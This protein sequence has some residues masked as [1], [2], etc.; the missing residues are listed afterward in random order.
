M[1]ENA[2]H[3]PSSLNTTVRL[4]LTPQF[5]LFRPLLVLVPPLIAGTLCAPFLLSYNKYLSLIFCLILFINIV[6]LFLKRKTLLF[7]VLLFFATGLLLGGTEIKM[8]DTMIYSKPRGSPISCVGIV[9][10]F[11]VRSGDRRQL[12][13][14]V[15]RQRGSEGWRNVKGKMRISIGSLDQNLIPGQRVAVLVWPLKP[16]NFGNPG[17][18]DYEGFLASRGIYSVARIKN[19]LY[20][21]P[22]GGKNALCP[23]KFFMQWREGFARN[24]ENSLAEPYAALMQAFIVGV[25]GNL[26]QDTKDI[27][28]VCGTGHLLAISGLHMGVIAFGGYLVILFLFRK[29]LFLVQR[30]N[31]FKWAFLPILPLLAVYT[32]ISGMSHSTFRACVMVLA[33]A[34][35]FLLNRRSD[36]VSNLSLAALAVIVIHPTSPREA[37]FQLS[38]VAVFGIIVLSPK[39][40]NLGNFFPSS[41]GWILFPRLLTLLAV[42]IAA[43]LVTIPFV[44]HHFHK[45]SLIALVTNIGV[46]PIITCWVVPIGLLSALCNPL[47]PQLASLGIKIAA[48]PLPYVTKALS[49]F[50]GIPFSNVHII[51]PNWLEVCI[52]FALLFSI[53]CLKSKRMARIALAIAV[54]IGLADVVYWVHNRSHNK[55]LTVTFLDVGQGN[56]ALV[57]LLPAK[58]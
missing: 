20:I 4:F 34:L 46:T 11:P 27:F 36:G 30:V 24:C 37:G 13:I 3:K 5:I 32:L 8:P 35:A 45:I 10:E 53:F 39:L 43:Y 15:E 12:L 52:Y 31:I 9:S 18:F 56:A 55:N 41:R 23:T 47:W 54:V 40:I 17:A 2:E 29:S 7:P 51:T 58:P 50:A 49:W 48:V 26:T 33:F 21:V 16:R 44:A 25:K 42:T 28:H 1:T 38:F 19:D 57:R 22:L 6:F 14:D